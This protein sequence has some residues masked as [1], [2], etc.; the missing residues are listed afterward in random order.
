VAL[1][2]HILRRPLSLRWPVP[3]GRFGAHMAVRVIDDG[4]VAIWLL[5]SAGF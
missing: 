3:T 1:A 2:R 4:P 5:D